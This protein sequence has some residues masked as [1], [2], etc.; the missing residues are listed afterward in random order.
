VAITS[1][2]VRFFWG[3]LSADLEGSS[4]SYGYPTQYAT[5]GPSASPAGGIGVRR[6]TLLLDRLT[7]ASPA[8]DAALMHFD[9]LNITGG[10]PDDTWIT[11][12]YTTLEGLI[13]TWWGT[14]KTYVPTWFKMSRILW[15]RVGPGIPLPNPAERILDIS[16]PVAGAASSSL[17][18]QAA[19]AITFRTGVR[20]S[21]GRTYLPL[22]TGVSA[23]AGRLSSAA[24]DAIA[25]PNAT[26]FSAALAADFH[27]VVV[28]NRLNSALGID[29][30]E[31]DDVI[32]VIRRRRWKHTVYR[33]LTTVA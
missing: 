27:P 5:L 33:K 7:V 3:A 8:D 11:S 16:S 28:S 12:D 30:L 17:P 19:C 29:Q 21:W 31:V 1:V 14:I 9:F 22:G 6:A 4:P 15:H 2:H 13:N 10:A 20:H 26:L 25:A 18:P 23:G 24:T 32:D